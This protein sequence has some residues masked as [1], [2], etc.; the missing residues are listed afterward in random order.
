[1]KTLR[2]TCVL[3]LLFAW[4]IVQA[5]EPVEGKQFRNSTGVWLGFYTKYRLSKNLYYNG[6]YHLRT[7]DGFQDMAQIYL[8]LGLSYL[9]TKHFEVTAGIVNP[10][11]WAPSDGPNIDKVVPQYRTW[12]QFIFFTPFDRLK[13]YHQIRIE[14]RWR[15][16]FHEGAPYQLDHRFRYKFSAYYPLN[17]P[18]LQMHTAFLSF[19]EEIFIQAGKPILY[20]YLEDNRIFLGLGYILNESLQFQTGY[21]YSFRHDGAP[22][23]YENRHI[24]RFSVFHNLDFYKGGAD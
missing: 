14:Q 21:M 8:R 4:G 2:L 17:K 5:Q 6:E 11:Y 9:V 24:F 19:Y 3:L 12:Q 20:N 23:K 22:N 15:R 16:D 10:Y 1:M 13:L 7:R 18:K